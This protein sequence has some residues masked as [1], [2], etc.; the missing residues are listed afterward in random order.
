MDSWYLD[1]LVCPRDHC[2]LR[3]QGN[4]LLCPHDHGYPVVDGTPVMLLSDVRQTM[5]VANTSI[6]QACAPHD[7]RGFY[8]ESLGLSDEEKRGILQL[9]ANNTSKVDPAVAYLIGATNGI[10]YKHL[11]GKLG[12]YPIPEM[13][14]PFGRG[15]SLLDIGCNWGRWCIAAARKGYG[16][17]GLD[18]SLGA[19]MAAKR[20]ATE[21]GVDIK[22]IVGD[23][24]FLPFSA[25]TI[26]NVF[27]YSV[28]Q[29][30]SREDAANVVVEIGRILKPGSRSLVQ[31]PT[32][33]GLRS[34]YH[35]ARR[36]FREAT[37]FD[38]RY[39]TIPELR[40][41]FSSQIGPTE[42]SV[43]C[44]FGI[45]L[46]YSDLHLMPLTHK[47]VIIASEILRRA[48]HLLPPLTVLADSV[49]VSSLKQTTGY[50]RS[51]VEC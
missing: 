45:G 8:V 12:E 37:G 14:L 35:Q 25:A 32:V 30:L 48:S 3:L 19:I 20:V 1:N 9:A 36:K 15:Q 33:F 6:N 47:T 29:H 21:E 23:A 34:L 42:F 49:Y 22:Y 39:W 43:D 50:S 31:M 44:F 38:V 28:V 51:E 24:R 13:R 46:Q 16:P 2:E 26:N 7:D 4:T 11:I 17:I 27:S 5:V 40:R 10:A 41:L 18:P